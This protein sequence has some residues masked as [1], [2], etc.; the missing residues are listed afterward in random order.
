LKAKTAAMGADVNR[1]QHGC[2]GGQIVCASTV[3]AMSQLIIDKNMANPSINPMAAQLMASPP[4]PI[5][6]QNNRKLKFD[7]GRTWPK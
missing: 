6:K 5:H 4:R 2:F 3:S 1:F 7:Y